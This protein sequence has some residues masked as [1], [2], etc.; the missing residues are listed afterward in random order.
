M[1][2]LVQIMFR[3][4]WTHSDKMHTYYHGYN[5]KVRI[6]MNGDG[7]EKGTLI[8]VFFLIFQRAL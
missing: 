7:L 6:Y 1:M 2:I 5:L 3:I 8:N 4:L